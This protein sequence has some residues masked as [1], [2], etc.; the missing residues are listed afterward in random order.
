[1]S[2]WIYTRGFERL[3]LDPGSSGSSSL[4]LSPGLNENELPSVKVGGVVS[5]GPI[6]AGAGGVAEAQGAPAQQ[7]AAEGRL[8]RQDPQG[9]SQ[10]IKVRFISV[11]AHI[12]QILFRNLFQH[13]S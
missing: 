9:G 7:T 12:W 11:R 4:D 3:G 8:L 5:R 10:S 2:V 1:M 13:A 6:A